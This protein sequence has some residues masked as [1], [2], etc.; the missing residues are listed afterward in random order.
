MH[1]EVAGLYENFYNMFCRKRMHGR[2][3]PLEVH[4]LMEGDLR[5]RLIG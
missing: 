2:L 3:V 1:C 4:C 5:T